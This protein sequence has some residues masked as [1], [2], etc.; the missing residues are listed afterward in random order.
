M[1]TMPTIPTKIPRWADDPEASI[2]EPPE[3]KKNAGWE[4][5]E[6]PPASYF[7]WW[8]NLVSV[9]LAWLQWVAGFVFEGVGG[10]LGF[11]R[12]EVRPGGDGVAISAFGGDDGSAAVAGTG[13][14]LTGPGVQGFGAADIADGPGGPGVVGEGK[15][16]GVHGVAKVQVGTVPASKAGVL[17]EGYNSHAG[18]RGVAEDNGH[19]VVAEAK[20]TGSPLHI[21]G[22]LA[23]PSNPVGGNVYYDLS[24]H[25]LRYY[26]GTS[27]V[28]L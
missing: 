1:A 10:R 12:I 7:N 28:D 27:W 16:V 2:V 22:R 24:S 4:A 21:V 6:K 14:G 23:A 11:T 15:S 25:K 5:A 19:G 17:G 9:W 26:N 8:M 13:R 18:V 20:G 3:L